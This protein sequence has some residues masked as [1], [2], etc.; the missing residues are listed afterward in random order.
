MSEAQAGIAEVR[1]GIGEVKNWR[2]LALA[3]YLQFGYMIATLPLI[4][5]LDP[6]M[7]MP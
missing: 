3:I 4:P 1:A 6:G 5:E 2:V 7:H